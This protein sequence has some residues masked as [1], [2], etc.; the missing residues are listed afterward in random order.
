MVK[1]ISVWSLTQQGEKQAE[2][3]AFIKN[4]LSPTGQQ[5]PVAGREECWS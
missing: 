3:V 5:N 1:A 2:M 4:V